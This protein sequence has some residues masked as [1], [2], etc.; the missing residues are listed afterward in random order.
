MATHYEVLGV[1]PDAS[2]E[3]I[4][5]A[6]RL[7]ARRHHPDV[8]PGTDPSV[9]AAI[10]GAWMVLSDPAQR[11]HYDAQLHRPQAEPPAR[12]ASPGQS[13]TG[14]EPLHWDDEDLDPEDESDEPYA[15]VPRRPSDMLVMTPVLLIVAAVAVFF[16]S[17]MSGS[18]GLRT[19]SMLL[20]P[21]SG[22]GF[23]MAPLMVMLRSK[24]RSTK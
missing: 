18:P 4:Q 13:G 21:I 12:P 2:G 1:A 15:D 7:L 19:F 14:W 3:A 20:I 22:I 17:I 10:N 9:M 6:Y 11:R 23:V 5:R 16:L 8:S 24:D